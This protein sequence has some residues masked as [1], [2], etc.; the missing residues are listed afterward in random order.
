MGRHGDQKAVALARGR[1]CSVSARRSVFP[2]AAPL[3]DVGEVTITKRAKALLK[4]QGVT[5]HELL[6]R[7]RRLDWPE[8]D[9]S[10]EGFG[11]NVDALKKGKVV[12]VTWTFG[13]PLQAS[14]SHVQVECT[15]G[16]TTIIGTEAEYLHR[17]DPKHY[18]PGGEWPKKTWGKGRYT[19]PPAEIVKTAGAEEAGA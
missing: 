19:A 7:F 14:R 5:V 16:K 4:K 17:A 15:P 9:G 11:Q 12:I 10:G 8:E 13:A 18:G 6:D 3:F 2:L 1:A